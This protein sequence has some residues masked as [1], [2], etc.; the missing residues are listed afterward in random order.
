MLTPPCDVQDPALYKVE[1]MDACVKPG[2]RFY[3]EVVGKATAGGIITFNTLPVDGGVS[4]PPESVR[5]FTVLFSYSLLGLAIEN[6]TYS[7]RATLVDNNGLNATAVSTKQITV[8]PVS[9]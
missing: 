4:I 8:S 3:V 2:V 7:I 6:G 9:D 1:P 5:K